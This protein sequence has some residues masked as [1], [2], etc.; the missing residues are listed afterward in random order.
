MS[1]KDLGPVAGLN[2]GNA[3]LKTETTT[4]QKWIDLYDEDW[5]TQYGVLPAETSPETINAVLRMI[6][7]AFDRG[8]ELGKFRKQREVCEALGVQALLRDLRG[9]IKEG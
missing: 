6:V 9:E 8:V 3:I 5:D 7:C 2:G 4:G 1:V